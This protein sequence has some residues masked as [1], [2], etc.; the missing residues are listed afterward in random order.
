MDVVVE[1]LLQGLGGQVSIQA[2][3]ATLHLVAGHLKI[4]FW[5]EQSKLSV[6][7]EISGQVFSCAY[8]WRP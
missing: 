8:G 7:Y 2:G 4:V 1:V 6:L 5:K 3:A